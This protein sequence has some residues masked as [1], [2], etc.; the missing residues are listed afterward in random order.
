MDLLPQ[1]DLDLGNPRHSTAG[2][3]LKDE[4]LP[5]ITETNSHPDL[6]VDEDFES[7]LEDAVYLRA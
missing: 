4:W 1:A 6:F 3:D 2:F 7:D 5:P